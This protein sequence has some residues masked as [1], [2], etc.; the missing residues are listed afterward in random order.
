MRRGRILAAAL[1]GGLLFLWL[2]IV[3]LVAYAVPVGRLLA[4]LVLRARR[5]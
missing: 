1:A 5:Q 3:L 4:A 2:P